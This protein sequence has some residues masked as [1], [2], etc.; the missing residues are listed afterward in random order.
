MQVATFIHGNRLEVLA[1]RLIDDELQRIDA[2]PFSSQVIVVAHP[3][4]GRWLQERI[5]LRLGIAANIAFPLPSSFAWDVLRD[6][7]GDLPKDS[8]FSRD[9]LTWRIHAALPA[10]ATQARFGPV[11][12][13][14]GDGGD[15]RKRFE[16][17]GQ[18]AR[19]YDEY[20][21]ARP[22]WI[23][24]WTR[25]ERIVHDEHE[26]W[27]SELWRHLVAGTGEE[28]R[29]SLMARAIERLRDATPRPASLPR[30]AAVFGAAFLPPLLLD[31]FLALATRVPLR[32]Y[33][34]NPC[35]DYWGDIVSGRER[36]RRQGLWKAHQRR[37]A[38]AHAET[39][40]P[41]LASWGML[42]REYLKAIHEP[43]VIVHDD[44]AFVAPDS[45]HL[46]GWLQKGILLLDPRHEAPPRDGLPSIEL[47][48]CPDRRREIEVLRNRL[49]AMI[50]QRPGLKPHDIVVMSPQVDAYVPYIDAVFG[51]ADE[52]LALPYR[53]SDVPLHRVHPLV[54][55]FLRVLALGDSRFS[56]SDVIG[57][58]AEPAIARRFHIDAE[59]QA[60]IATW[61]EQAAIRW[62]LDA[63]FRAAVG[64]APIDE[65]S[66]RF[67]FDRLLLGHAL[68]DD[69]TLVAGIA[70]AI[71]VEGRDARAL[72]ELARFV[73]ALAQTRAG[74]ATPRT[75]EAWKTWLGARFEAVFDTEPDDAAE[76]A[77]VR[78]LQSAIRSFA[79]MAEP[80]LDGER[81]P[82]EVVR[83]A[84]E[85]ALAEP[86]ATRSGRFGITFCGMVPMRNVPHRVVCV[87]GLDAGAFPRR[88]P[89]PGFNLMRRHPRAGD[90]S[91]REDDRFL[92]LEALV[93]ARDVFYLSHVDRDARSGGPSPPSP[94]VEEL[95][96]FLASAHGE[97]W[98]EVA[99]HLRTRH[100]MHPF[101]PACFGDDA[102]LRSYDT[103]W[104]AAAEAL[105]RPWQPPRAFAEGARAI[106]IA[107]EMPTTIE[108]DALLAWL[109][110]PVADWFRRV[111]PLRVH[112]EDA[113]G[114]SEP[115]AIDGLQR[116]VIGDRLLGGAERKPDLHRVQR[117]GVFPLGPAGDLL[118]GDLARRADAIEAATRNWIGE[119]HRHLD[120]GRREVAIAG[121]ALR[122]A[123]TPRLWI[124]GNV[125]AL[126]LRRMGRLRGV[127]LARMALERFLLGADAVALPARALGL[128]GSSLEH[129]ELAP[130]AD[131]AAWLAAL[132]EAHVASRRWPVPLFP[133]S[134]NAYAQA[135]AGS[136]RRSPEAAALE[137]WHGNE[138][139]PGEKDEPLNALFTRDDH[140]P[141]VSAEFARLA[142]RIYLP[143]HQAATE[144]AP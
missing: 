56:S 62:G 130:L 108:L 46:L 114:D 120:A 122:V 132:I 15:A 71:N 92:F 54:D 124:E 107:D 26:P 66:W 20:M 101:D 64:A 134:A 30:H 98:A 119:A 74:F 18:L 99:G 83:V 72:G 31:F 19:T 49:L 70:P 24:A 47:H 96:E 77:A 105:V 76:L 51:G 102:R 6:T 69:A 73:D 80:W 136:G 33:Q 97:A 35:L 9:A 89:P 68:G 118:W 5:A 126:L 12:R 110:D 48:G 137:A 8:A 144:V 32:F 57:L 27:Q 61:V 127:D 129:I 141:V 143:L 133:R 81:L 10:L 17:A 93:A 4:L 85:T 34:P 131:E 45:S 79:A 138:N 1:E 38:L 115:F 104:R 113:V 21:V 60:W 100:R 23:R 75:A 22:D 14:L 128:E 25:G 91:V 140:V 78:A 116:Y 59:G 84:L 142:T 58:L 44:D 121:T 135:L 13:Y 52:A 109:R 86:V 29:A 40:H 87:L 125:R 94:L 42:G 37:D 117:E 53:I 28:G 16:L 41:L 3:A 11:R 111:L 90:R 139:H 123:G 63:P 65:N 103:A 7:L 112:V 106:D 95:F 50:E 88:Q 67:G 2:D 43:E 36:T 82:F 39:G 55:A